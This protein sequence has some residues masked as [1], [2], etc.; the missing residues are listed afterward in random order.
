MSARSIGPISWSMT[1]DEDGQRD[2]TVVFRVTSDEVIGPA[3]ALQASDLPQEGDTWSFPEA[4]GESDEWAWCRYN[5]KVTPVLS[6]HEPTKDWDLEFLF[7]TKPVKRCQDTQIE[8]PLLIPPK[9]SGS[10]VRYTE[11]AAYDRFGYP[12]LNSAFEMMRGPKVEFDGNRPQ[13]KIEMNVA[14]L[15]LA[16]VQAMVDK[17]NAYPL[18]GLPRRCIKLSAAPWE[19]KFYGTCNVYFTYTLEFDIRYDTFD[20]VLLDEGTKVLNGHWDRATGNWALDPIKGLS[21]PSRPTLTRI[22]GAGTLGAGTYTYAV[23]SV[24]S[25]GGETLIS[26]TTSAT[27]TGASNEIVIRW[28]KVSGAASYK[29]YGRSA[30]SLLFIATVTAPIL[31]YTDTGAVTPSGDVPTADTTIQQPNPKNPQHFIQFIDRRGNPTKV[32]LN[33]AGVPA[34]VAVDTGTGTISA[35]YVSIQNQNTNHQ[36]TDES[37]WILITPPVDP[38]N[39]PTWTPFD[40]YEEG[41]VVEWQDANGVSNLYVALGTNYDQQPPDISWYLVIP[42]YI[43]GLSDHD[44]FF[45]GAWSQSTTYSIGQYV[46]YEVGPQVTTAGRIFVQKYDEANFEI[47][48]I[49]LDLTANQ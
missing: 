4:N 27:V 29:V 12:I 47:L 2:Y 28:P 30:S 1:R 9:I 41:D 26:Q 32:V 23:T 20:R 13:V 42:A 22:T 39:I 40:I 16:L 35:Y 11:E 3:L 38:L 15:N 21:I 33:G 49:P 19:R 24:D 44:L 31:F 7:S 36:P 25:T 5:T 10:F 45:E 14:Q 18:W 34:G 43:S 46:H 48:G 17:L 37:Q 8:D 6:K